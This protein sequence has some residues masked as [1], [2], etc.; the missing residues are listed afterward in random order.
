MKKSLTAS[1]DS[2]RFF[3]GTKRALLALLWVLGTSAFAPAGAQ[4]TPTIEVRVKAQSLFV[5]QYPSY[6]EFPHESPQE[7]FDYLQPFYTGCYG[8]PPVCTTTSNLRP[9]GNLEI[10]GL[11]FYWTWDTTQCELGVCHP[12]GQ[13]SIVQQ[14]VCQTQPIFTGLSSTPVSFN[15]VTIFNAQDTNIRTVYCVAH[16]PIPQPCPTCGGKPSDSRAN[17]IHTSTGQKY[18]IESDYAAAAG[19]LQFARTYTS[20]NGSFSSPATSTW[21]DDSQPGIDLPGCLPG[22]YIDSTGRSHSHCYQYQTTGN[23]DYRLH[24]GD[25]RMIVFGG[26]PGA[27]TASADVNERVSQRTNAAGAI[28]WVV[29]RPDNSTEIYNVQG[30]LTRR[31]SLDG[32]EDLSYSYSDG[33]TPATIAPK[34]GLLIGMAD[35]FGRSLGFT[36]DTLARVTT[37]TDP[38]G[39]VFQYAYDANGNLASVAYPD[40][41]V[42][43]YQY[44]EAANINNGTVCSLGA[45]AYTHLLTGISDNGQRFA[46]FKYD[47]NGLAVS[48][49][50]AGSVEKY[51]FAYSGTSS[52]SPRTTEVD[53]LGTSRTYGFQQLLSTV[54]PTSTQQ[55]AASGTGTATTSYTYD[56]NGNVAS[57]TDYNGNRTA[58]TYEL[59]RNL[60][61]QRVEA[62]GTPQA[63]TIS[64]QWSTLFRLQTKVAEPLRITTYV[65]GGDGGAN[66]GSAADGTP[67]QGVLCSKTIQATSD[68]NGSQGF[69]ATA[70]GAPRAW[71]YTY[72][73]N[74]LPLT[75]DGPRTD[76]S[77]LT[78]YTYYADDDADMGKRG[79]V[80]SVTNALGQTT[81]ITAYNAHG[82]PTTIVDANGLTTTLTYDARM[83]LTSRAVGGETTSYAY[84]VNG[85]L[86]LVTLPDGSSLSYSY[87]AAHRLTGMSD[88]LGNHI[89]YALDNMGNRTQEQVLDPANN[90]AQTRSRVFNALNRL[91]QEIGAAGQTTQYAYDNQGNVTSVADPLNHVTT[92]A[93]DALNR[94]AQVTDPNNGVT[95]YGYNGV[96]QLVSVTDPRNLA[97]T[98]AYDGLSNLNSQVSPDTGTTT[99]TYDTAG[100]LLTQRDAKSQTTTYAYDALN[101]VTSIT[102][103]DGSKQN[104]TYDQGPNGI[105]RLTQITELDPTQNITSQL[106]YGYDQHGRVTSE[107][108]TI[109]GVAYLAAYQYDSSGRLSGMT[110]PSGRSI[111]YS[112]DALGR[113]SQVMS[114][115]AAAQGGQTQ[116][117]VQNV[118][119][120]PFGG[121]KSY[122]L[123][124]GQI[125]T[126]GFDLDG[127]IA[128]YNL[129]AQNFAIGYDPASRVSFIADAANPAN[130]NNYGYDVLDR[131]TNAVTPGTPYAYNYD[132][133]GN[134][135]SKT[136]G[137][138]T[139]T[140]AYASTSNRL[141]SITSQAGAAR[142]FVFD[143]NGSTTNDGN[144]QYVYDTRGRMVQSVGVLGT[145][146]YQVNALGQRFRKT[147]SQDDRIFLYDT[148]GHLISENDPGGGLKREYLYLG[149]IPVAVIQ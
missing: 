144:N 2:P 88:N 42:R 57:R 91:F 74:G 101:R 96:D 112:F 128:S 16:I 129:G 62:Q 121:V 51:S 65:W 145:T 140:Y 11:S 47:C 10:N 119:Y 73:A 83:R 15:A 126:R 138:S 6:P 103:A 114:T 13:G 67:L 22:T 17:P 100:N 38:A 43:T 56:A 19:G 34:P 131:L 70:V 39:G 77:D 82:Q 24:T 94:L 133:V 132:V 108:R 93:Y 46:T 20:S 104:Y 58:Y 50:H 5:N 63:R 102:F 109:A 90:L 122:T 66:C 125:Y 31:T 18:Q 117:V 113:V 116:T 69:G 118:Q 143:A 9:T 12:L 106:A 3:G 52:S 76:V 124:N 55:P 80:A 130:A 30:Q 105:G 137:S 45:N 75:I 142:S 123:G 33:T 8:I 14:D 146:T 84:D 59:A 97:T 60:E 127:R 72:N 26:T 49:E 79:N 120:Q 147:N 107:T 141:A 32:R 89:A 27:I 25:G 98:Y 54:V 78:T 115:A 21:V 28:E 95:R 23:P 134:R 148:K 61:I 135:T 37:M 71:T 111:A 149:D 68:A 35:R 85:Q 4:T 44:G 64:T 7:A 110:Y 92:N 41:A 139:D 136:V 86:I 40:A 1:V 48:S 36:Y 87:D 81:S 53:P 99:N 29:V